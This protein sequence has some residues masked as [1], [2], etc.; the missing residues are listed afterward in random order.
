M[1]ILAD[2]EDRNYNIFIQY[3]Y[4][5]MQHCFVFGGVQYNLPVVSPLTIY[6]FNVVWRIKT[7]VVI[8]TIPLAFT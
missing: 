7:T 6:Y 4:N 3:S 8:A 5:F 2:L 1:G